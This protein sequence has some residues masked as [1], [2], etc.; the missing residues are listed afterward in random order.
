MELAEQMVIYRA[1]HNLTQ[2]D[3]AK[4]VGV[5]VPTISSIENGLQNPTKRTAAKIKLVI[6]Q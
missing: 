3:L 5:S 6:G 2:A 1:R 4:L